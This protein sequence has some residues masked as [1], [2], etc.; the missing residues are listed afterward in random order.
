MTLNLSSISRVASASSQATS[1]GEGS[2]TQTFT[3]TVTAPGLSGGYAAS[4][5]ATMNSSGQLPSATTNAFA[6]GG[7]INSAYNNDISS[8]YNF[9]GQTVGYTA[10]IS[11][12]SSH[13]YLF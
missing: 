5:A 10:S 11:F 12:A 13:G 1:A 3:K 7:N 9:N 6:S 4:V 2:L 8:L